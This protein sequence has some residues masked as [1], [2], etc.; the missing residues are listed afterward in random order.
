MSSPL[1]AVVVP[2]EI[3][4]DIPDSV[5]YNYETFMQSKE[6]IT[7][8]HQI[9]L[10]TIASTVSRGVKLVAVRNGNRGKIKKD[11]VR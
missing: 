10:D 9:V 11:V 6:I 2:V 8:I 4:E 3:P 1:K 7:T 5:L